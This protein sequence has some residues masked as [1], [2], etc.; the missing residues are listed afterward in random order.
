MKDIKFG[1]D[2]WRAIIDKE[3]TDENVKMVSQA[4]A[5]YVNGLKDKEELRGKELIVGYDTRK[6]SEDFAEDAARVLAG[7]GIKVLLSDRAAPTPAISFAIKKRHLTGGVIIT[8]SHNPANYNG[9]KYKAFYSG[10]AD[11]GIIGK[12]EANFGKNPVREISIGEAKS[13]GLLRTENV[14][15]DQIHFVEDYCDMGLLKNSGLK[16]LIDS[17]HGVGG[18]FIQDILSK[19]NC[20]V[21]TIHAERDIN[22]GGVNP[23]PIEKYLGEFLEHMKGKEYDIGLATDGDVDRIGAA[24]PGGKFLDAQYIMALLLLH[25]VEDKKMTGSVVSTICGTELLRKICEK[26]KLKLH[27]TPVGF[28]YICDHMRTEDVLIGGEEA[29]GIGF[30][31]YIPERDGILSGLLL[32]EMMAHRKKSI[33]DILKDI[34]EEYGSYYYLKTST[35]V[36]ED[37]KKRLMPSL[38]KNHLKEV[39]GKKVVD[40][41]TLDGIKFICEDSSWLLFRLSGTEP[42]LRIYAEA[43]SRERA[44]EILEYGKKIGTEFSG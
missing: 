32:L 3:F 42:I 1:T 17:M 40:V 9:F 36:T 2:G 31:D 15:P 6:K 19:T 24:A 39:L 38:E 44:S 23:E 41:D 25:F 4:V 27:I 16:V 14:I 12:I 30:K 43:A 10:S 5:D 8:A 28:K 11:P 20:K 33:L 22:F 13:E 21:E 26:Y 18:H 29:G 7:N 34:E 37:I 35:G